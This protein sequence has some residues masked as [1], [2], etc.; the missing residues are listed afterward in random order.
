MLETESKDK[1]RTML[2]DQSGNHFE[3]QRQQKIIEK[4]DKAKIT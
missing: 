3:I 4:T 2:Q 1:I